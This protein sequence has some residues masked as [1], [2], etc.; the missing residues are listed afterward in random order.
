MAHREAVALRKSGPARPTTCTATCSLRMIWAAARPLPIAGRARL[1]HETMARCVFA[2]FSMPDAFIA[3]IADLR[4]RVTDIERGD[5]G[6][7]ID[8]IHFGFRQMRLNEVA[9]ELEASARET[10]GRLFQEFLGA[11]AG[12]ISG[13]G[14]CDFFQL[15]TGDP[16][17][18][19][20]FATFMR[21]DEGQSFTG[22]T[23]AAGAANAVY[24][25]FG[26]AWDVKV[27]DQTN[28]VDI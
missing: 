7:Q 11:V 16:L 15:L 13:S 23:G 24:I 25:G 12:N 5:R 4:A 27:H 3:M 14:N 8:G 6:E 10:F 22:A 26:F 1:F 9:V 18:I 17:D 28:A 19:A 2:N 21:R 20:Q